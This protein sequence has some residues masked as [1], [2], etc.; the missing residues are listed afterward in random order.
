M[1]AYLYDGTKIGLF[2]CI[3]IEHGGTDDTGVVAHGSG[4]NFGVGREEAL[5]VHKL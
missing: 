4:D 2:T 1:I 5:L 3:F